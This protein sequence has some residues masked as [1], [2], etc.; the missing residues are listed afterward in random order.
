MAQ[1]RPTQTPTRREAIEKLRDAGVIDKLKKAGLI[2]END[3]IEGLLKQA[4][5]LDR[6][7]SSDETTLKY[8]I[9]GSKGCLIK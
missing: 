7:S 8:V 3:T 4:S 5:F 6:Q 9:C 2:P 1:K